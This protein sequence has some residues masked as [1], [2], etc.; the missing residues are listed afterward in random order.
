LPEHLPGAFV[1]NL[2]KASATAQVLRQTVLRFPT[3]TIALNF[4]LAR[5]PTRFKSS[6]NPLNC[7]EKISFTPTGSATTTRI[8]FGYLNSS[9]NPRID[10]SKF[11][12]SQVDERIVL[13]FPVL[14]RRG[15]P[16]GGFAC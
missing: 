4:E 5:W 13:T 8:D 6:C 11:Q 10:A 3:P 14:P 2:R 15:G 7:F 1:F 9:T 16:A 12:P